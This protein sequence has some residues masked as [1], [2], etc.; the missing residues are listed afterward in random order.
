MDTTPNEGTTV[1][2]TFYDSNEEIAEIYDVCMWELVG[3][4][5]DD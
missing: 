4:D 2:C 3:E 1:T 5:P